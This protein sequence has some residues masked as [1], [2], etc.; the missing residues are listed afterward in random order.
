MLVVGEREKNDGTVSVRTRAG[1]DK[2]AVK[3]E[4]FLAQAIEE[5]RTKAR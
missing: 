3:L 4:E 1:E 2:G 5:I